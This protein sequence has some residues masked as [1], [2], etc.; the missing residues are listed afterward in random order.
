MT[1]EAAAASSSEVDSFTNVNPM[2]GKWAASAPMAP[3]ATSASSAKGGE[4]AAASRRRSFFALIVSLAAFIAVFASATGASVYAMRLPELP[5]P[6]P[7]PSATASASQT[8][9]ATASPSPTP[10]PVRGGSWFPR[11]L[12]KD[13]ALVSTTPDGRYVLAAEWQGTL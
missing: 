3:D 12:S 9:S 11:G 2:A 13:Y 10:S 8:P 5:P 4:D 6:T 7:S 1:K